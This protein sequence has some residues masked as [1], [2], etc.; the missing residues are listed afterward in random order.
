MDA[1]LPSMVE[2][3]F[4]GKCTPASE[5]FHHFLPALGTA[6]AELRVEAEKL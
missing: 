5:T 1:K 3:S 6:N 4:P 2:K